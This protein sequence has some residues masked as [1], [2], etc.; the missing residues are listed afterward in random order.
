MTDY[1]GDDEAKR[2]YLC[3][4]CDEPVDWFMIVCDECSERD[5]KQQ[6]RDW[7][8][9]CAWEEHMAWLAECEEEEMNAAGLNG[10]SDGWIQARRYAV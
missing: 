5:T 7:E 2:E 1:D 3:R 8:D 4:I 10:S 6:L 9:E